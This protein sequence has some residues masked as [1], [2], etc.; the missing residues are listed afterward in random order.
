MLNNA[1]HTEKYRLKFE[2]IQDACGEY[3]WDTSVLLDLWTLPANLCPF[4]RTSGLFIPRIPTSSGSLTREMYTNVT[5]NKEVRRNV[6]IF[7]GVG[8]V[9]FV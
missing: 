8:L 1:L 7:S 6:L 4:L 9:V 5:V 2:V 3:V